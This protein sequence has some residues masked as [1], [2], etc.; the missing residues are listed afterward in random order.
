MDSVKHILVE[1]INENIL[2]FKYAGAVMSD[3]TAEQWIAVFTCT[4]IFSIIIAQSEKSAL[5]LLTYGKTVENKPDPEKYNS[6]LFQRFENYIDMISD[7]KIPKSYFVHYY[8]FFTTMTLAQMFVGWSIDNNI[9]P[10][11]NEQVT[12]LYSSWFVNYD[13]IPENYKYVYVVS[14]LLAIQAFKRLYENL[15]VSKFSD[16]KMNILH[17]IFGIM[18]YL[19]VSLTNFAAMFPYYGGEYKVDLELPD[20]LFIF[21]YLFY[22]VDQYQNHVHLASLVKYTIPTFRL[23]E[24]CAS[25]HYLDEIIMYAVMTRFY[26]VC[27]GMG[28]IKIDFILISLLVVANLSVSATETYRYYQIKF[29]D[30]FKI[31]HKMVPYVW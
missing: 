29:G 1:K 25:P 21:A 3:F 8:I 19:A 12:K 5:K 4:C 23:F 30:K 7:W 2:F 16:S 6:A 22:L 20:W 17:Y 27:D 13:P 11:F 31:P 28:W 18:F 10:Q 14:N 9:Y 26:V 15:F 24:L